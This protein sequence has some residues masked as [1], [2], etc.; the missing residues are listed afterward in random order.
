MT[1]LADRLAAAE[2]TI[3]T[4]TAEIARLRAAK[5]AAL[6]LADE[7]AKEA[8]ELRQRLEMAETSHMEA[9]KENDVLREKF[10]LVIEH[11]E[12]IHNLDTEGSLMMLKY[13]EAIDDWKA[14]FEVA[15]IIGGDR[16]L[17]KVSAVLRSLVRMGLAEYGQANN[18]FRVTQ[19]GR[20]IVEGA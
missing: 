19:S 8:C 2:E 14:P 9:C 4:L 13:L 11:L 6:K 5:T 1:V 12:A 15:A 7:R 3:K 10:A 20:E 18:T 16:A 17:E